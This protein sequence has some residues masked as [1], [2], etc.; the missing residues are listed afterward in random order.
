MMV[1]PAQDSPRGRTGVGYCSRLPMPESPLHVFWHDDALRHDTGSGVFDGVPSPLI[2]VPELHPENDVRVRNIRSC[3]RDGPLAP[4]LQ[5]R[6]GRHAALD[7]LA[8]LH[9]PAYV[10]GVRR[11][12]EAGGGVLS[13]ATVVS[14][15]RWDAALASAGTAIAAAEAVAGG[16]C[17]AAYA[18]VRPPGHHAQPAMTDGY[19]L[20]SNTALAAEAALRRGAERVAVIDWDVHHGN[21]TQECLYS[22]SDVLTISLHM[23][24]GSWGPTHPQTGA[25]D[26]V[27]TGEGEGFNVNVEL[28]Y[29]SGDAAYER[30][31]RRLVMPL[32]DEFRPDLIIAAAGQDA[33]QFDPNGR[34][35]VTMAG[36]R[37]LGELS[38]ELAERHCGGRIALIQEGGYG[39]TYSAFCAHATLEGVIGVGPLLEDPLAFM[40]DE[41]AR[42]DAG[43]DA[44]LAVHRRYW[45]L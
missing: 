13:W 32:V 22:R 5:W 41:Q 28:A 45:A 29:G 35:C 30:A 10:E 16:D 37:R 31:M 15:G 8:W 23:P 34:Q 19:C 43:I 18:L 24:H 20:F 33:S 4:H 3:L 40:P 1:D 26:E 21:G 17:G 14:E 27:G 44:A 11:F 25:P 6:A 9:D 39:R 7:E 42:G 38:A 36:F 2:E 12:C